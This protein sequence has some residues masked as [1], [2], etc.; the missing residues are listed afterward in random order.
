MD[1]ETFAELLR[2]SPAEARRIAEEL[3]ADARMIRELIW[4]AE[5]RPLPS[6]PRPEAPPSRWSPGPTE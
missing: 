2:M 6:E 4:L 5:R 1:A 3:E